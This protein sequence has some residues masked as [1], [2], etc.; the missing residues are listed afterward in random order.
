M[1]TLALALGLAGHASASEGAPGVVIETVTMQPAPQLEPLLAQLEPA[2]SLNLRLDTLPSRG[3]GYVGETAPDTLRVLPD[4]RRL[5]AAWKQGGPIM[6]SAVPLSGSTTI[7][8]TISLRNTLSVPAVLSQARMEVEGTFVDRQPLLQLAYG[9]WGNEGLGTRFDVFNFGWGN[10]VDG[11]FTYAFLNPDAPADATTGTTMRLRQSFPATPGATWRLDTRS[12]LVRLGV[13]MNQFERW[14]RTPC[15]ASEVPAIQCSGAGDRAC[16]EDLARK[17]L[18]GSLG[19]AVTMKDGF[20]KT[21]IV[22][23]ADFSWKDRDGTMKAARGPFR[24]TIGLGRRVKNCDSE[25]K[26]LQPPPAPPPPPP[27]PELSPDAPFPVDLMLDQ[28]AYTIDLPVEQTLAP[29]QRATVRLHIRSGK[30]ST[31]RFRVV[32][33]ANGTNVTSPAVDLLAFVARL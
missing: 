27:P 32:L 9:G 6:W 21:D 20:L 2:L 26:T 33:K 11:Q 18:L 28:T 25:I 31:S 16:L 3:M 29:G 24:Q 5:L 30:S 7:A 23:T 17:G 4:N 19:N 13:N 22:G 8:L 14:A 12:G 10:P 1:M 15:T